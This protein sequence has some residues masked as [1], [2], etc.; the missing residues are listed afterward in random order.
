MIFATGNDHKFKT[1]KSHFPEATQQVMDIIEP[2]GSV[3]EIATLKCNEAWGRLQVPVVAEDTS[4]EFGKSGLPGPYIKYFMDWYGPAE[5]VPVAQ[6]MASDMS[7][8]FTSV[9]AYKMT[10]DEPVKCLVHKTKGRIVP[11]RGTVDT[12][13]F[14]TIFEVDGTGKT[15]A[16]MDAAMYRKHC[17]RHANARALKKVWN[18]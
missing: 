4:L 10:E 18:K 13:A 11:P 3:V 15:L 6:V 7:A 9:L 17:P 5:L 2:Q 14:N 8:T 1:L 16:E 12:E